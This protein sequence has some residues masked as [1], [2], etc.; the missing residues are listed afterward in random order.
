VTKVA[1]AAPRNRKVRPA[2]KDYLALISEL[3]IRPIETA[4][5]YK[6]AQ[7]I[8]DWLVGRPDLTP[9]QR[10]YIAAVARF[11]VEY[12]RLESPRRRRTAPHQSWRERGTRRREV[13]RAASHAMVRVLP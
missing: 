10:D 9:G 13:P 3:P 8:K 11:M 2:A 5:E 6:V 1:T 7:S 4:A 12:E